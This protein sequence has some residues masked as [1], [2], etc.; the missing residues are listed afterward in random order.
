M[1]D[2]GIVH[3]GLNANLSGINESLYEVS[4]LSCAGRIPLP[5]RLSLTASNQCFNY[6]AK[7][8]IPMSD[9]DANLLLIEDW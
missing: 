4:Y 3:F 1:R 9:R 8:T 5:N 2:K 7:I 6:L